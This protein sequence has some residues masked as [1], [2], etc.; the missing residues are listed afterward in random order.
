MSDAIIVALITGVCAVIGN[1]AVSAQATKDLFAKLDKR[2]DLADQKLE[3]EM[4]A[5]RAEVNGSLQVMQT[6]IAQLRGT[7]EK[8]NGVI[9]RTFR[10]EE[11][12]S[13]LE[14]KE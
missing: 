6:E 13:N 2:S 4:T 10:L 9:E 14:H 3:G 12:V 8:H 7:V 5:F 1:V 11:R